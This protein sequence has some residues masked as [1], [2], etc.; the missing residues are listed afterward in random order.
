MTSLIAQDLGEATSTR[1]AIPQRAA[2]MG[3]RMLEMRSHAVIAALMRSDATVTLRAAFSFAGIEAKRI[4][5]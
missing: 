3:D 2:R 5:Y 1:K 4:L